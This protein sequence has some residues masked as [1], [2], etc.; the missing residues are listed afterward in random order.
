[1]GVLLEP[2][3]KRVAPY[4]A[5][6]GEV[7]TYTLVLVNGGT[8]PALSAHLHDPL[9]GGTT[10][11]TGWASSGEYAFDEGVHWTGPI[12]PFEP[13]TVT[14]RV[15]VTTASLVTNVATLDDGYGGVVSVTAWLNAERVL[16]PLLTRA[17]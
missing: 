14:F 8:A 7:A 11:I 12:T 1:M 3:R 9:P 17:N 13:V 5:G 15:T 4:Q 6:I 10:H 16:L 2:S